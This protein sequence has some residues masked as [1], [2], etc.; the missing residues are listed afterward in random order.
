MAVKITVDNFHEKLDPVRQVLVDYNRVN[1]AIT[2]FNNNATL[3]VFK[4]IFDEDAER[5]WEAFRLKCD[6]KY[7][8]FTSYL[9]PNQ[10]SIL[11]VSLYI[12]KEDLYW[13]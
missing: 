7:E 5:L 13:M 12:N 3:G 10:K 2:S 6:G 1:E 4:F 9:T 8:K 11:L